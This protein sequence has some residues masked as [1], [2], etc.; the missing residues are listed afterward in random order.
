MKCRDG[1][2]SN[3][4]SSSFIINLPA[5]PTDKENFSKFF[6]LDAFLIDDDDSI[7]NDDATG[8]KTQMYSYVNCTTYHSKASVIELLW[9]KMGTIIEIMNLPKEKAVE[10]FIQNFKT[11]RWFIRLDGIDSKL[12]DKIFSCWRDYRTDD[13]DEIQLKEACSDLYD[14][15]KK[16]P[17]VPVE[18]SDND[19]FEYLFYNGEFFENQGFETSNFD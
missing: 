1:F 5:Y 19:S 17:R 6:K 14:T 13:V 16:H 2:V 7:N 11:N 18:F 15:L 10:R 9:E 3:S 4:S 12:D 8:I